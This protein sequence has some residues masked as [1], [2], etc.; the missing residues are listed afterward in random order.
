MHQP[1]GLLRGT[2]HGTLQNEAKP[3]QLHFP[4]QFI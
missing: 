1:I 4:I 3:P 2:D